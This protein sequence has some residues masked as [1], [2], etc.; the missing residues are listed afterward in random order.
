METKKRPT[1]PLKEASSE[2]KQKASAMPEKNFSINLA[3]SPN[4]CVI[5]LG[6]Q[7]YRALVD[8][9]AEVSLVHRRVFDKLKHGYDLGKQ[10]V[11]LQ[12]VNGNKLQV[13]GCATIKFKLG[14]RKFQ[15]TFYVVDGL[16][17][18]VILGRDWIIDNM[19][20][21]YFNELRSMKIGQVYVPLE[22]DI[23]ISALVR[24]ASTV[25]I[26]P[27]TAVVC[28]AK[29]SGVLD[30]EGKQLCQI[31]PT[32]RGY[33]SMEPGLQLQKSV[34]EVKAGRT[35]AALISNRTSRTFRVKR[36]SV[37]GKL[38][39]L[40]EE[41]IV[42]SVR[43][44]GEEKGKA[45]DDWLD[46]LSVPGDFEG[47][48]K[49]LVTENRD[50]FA[51]TDAELG[52][53]DTVK[54]K[55]DTGE[56]PPIKMKPYRTPLNKR[57]VI[58]NAVDEM[59]EAGGII[60][61]SQS[62]WSFP[63]VVVD[64]KD[65]SKRF[66]VDF[67]QLNK[68]TKPISYPLPVIDDILAR[69][70]KAKYFTTLDLKS[71]YWQ[72]L[73]DERDREKTAFA[74]HRGLFEFLVM[75]FG[76]SGAPPTKYLGFTING[77][78][79]QP[80][81]EKV[82]A[83]REMAAP[84]NVREV[85]GFIGTCSYYRRFI[86]NFSEI[87]QPHIELTKKF[88]RFKW[89]VQCQ[90]AFDYL[91]DSLTVVP[92]LV[93]PDTQKPYVLYTDA[94]DTCIGAVLTQKGE[95]GEGKEVEKPIYFLS[96]KLSDTQCRWS[97]I[98]KEAYAIHYSLQKLDHYL[99]GAEF[100]VRT[101]H[102]PLKYL[103]ESLMQNR[104]VQMWAL[105]IAGYNCQIEYIEGVANTVADLL[106]RTPQGCHKVQN[107]TQGEEEVEI[108]DKFLEVNALNSNRFD[109]KF[110]AGWENPGANGKEEPETTWEGMDMV[111][112]QD[113]DGVVK[114]IKEQLESGK[115]VGAL[116]N[117][118]LILGGLLYY[119]SDPDDDPTPRLYIPKQLQD[120]VIKQYHDD[121]GHM[122]IDKTFE[123]I[124]RK[125]YFPNLYQKLTSYVNAC[126]TCQTRALKKQRPPL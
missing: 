73:M 29:T 124:K 89:T 72:V 65:G 46:D 118:H 104:K 54:M 98:E 40:K 30:S 59:L 37:I 33:L 95:D 48:V 109:P 91:K 68:I 123:S 7:R 64:K 121:N 3:G 85:R 35:F 87:A 97:T 94:S 93:Y 105:S 114:G 58:D 74:C 18:N 13:D 8:T 17:R 92:L 102:K 110:Y 38:E 45:G 57:A 88:A 25:V 10:K 67:R 49:K 51:Q 122:G 81:P 44:T 99:H 119:L 36:G 19:V 20:V 86:P 9:G 43:E 84:S 103:L 22:E 41:N 62:P 6:K 80:D 111:E 71:G 107:K 27:H 5:Q 26:K 100:I 76:L 108:S 50:L 4:S 90:K 79:I 96:H 75:P 120:A 34:V 39:R 55:L 12:A 106:S 1:P 115:A 21:L 77:E 23:H 2:R 69:L 113:K 15:H 60:R 56:H 16:N 14:G 66:C 125:Y 24:A 63:V 52:H 31:S 116:K 101:D 47:G 32:D 42:N 61:R 126:V 83:I 53:T 28:K 82:E 112:E 11:N 117:R 70:G 78:G